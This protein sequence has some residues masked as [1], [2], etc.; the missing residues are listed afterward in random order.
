MAM[1]QQ[2]FQQYQAMLAQQMAMQQQ[3]MNTN[4]TTPAGGNATA[5][6]AAA[7]GAMPSMIPMMNAQ[8]PGMPG[9]TG[10]ASTQ[11]QFM[12][13]PGFMP[14]MPFGYPNNQMQGFQKPNEE[15]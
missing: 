1:H 5:N 6:P 8:M 9:A 13:M 4:G 14:T 12:A 10:D 7:F 11:Q 2:M 3:M 15:K